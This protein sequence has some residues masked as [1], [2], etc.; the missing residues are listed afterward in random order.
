M[1]LVGT[2]LEK[3]SYSLQYSQARLQRRMGMICASRGWSV[4]VNAWAIIRAP[5]MLRWNAFRRRRTMVRVEGIMLFL[6]KHRHCSS[7]SFGYLYAFYA[8]HRAP[9]SESV[10]PQHPGS[11]DDSPGVHL[12]RPPSAGAYHPH[13]AL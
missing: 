3:S 7:A 1:V 6:L 5:R 11:A 4:E 9:P 8:N 2:G 12:H 13:P 10:P